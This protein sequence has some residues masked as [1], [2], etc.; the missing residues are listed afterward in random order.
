LVGFAAHFIRSRRPISSRR[1]L[2]VT[3]GILDLVSSP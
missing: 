2:W 1:A 3:R